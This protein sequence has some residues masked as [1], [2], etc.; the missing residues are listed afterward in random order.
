MCTSPPGVKVFSYMNSATCLLLM[1]LIL[2][3]WLPTQS[4]ALQTSFITTISLF[5]FVTPIIL[6]HFTKG[7]VFQLFH[8]ANEDTYKAV[9]RNIFLMEKTT[10][11]KQGDVR[12]PSIA[13]MFSTFY[14]GRMGMLVHPDHFVHP[15]DY[16]HLMGYDQPFTFNE[17]DLERPDKD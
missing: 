1:P 12:I 9:T 7:Y 10:V 3:A 2:N 17:E 8:N 15:S 5:T 11:F 14:A 13:K 6:H 16:S 4:L